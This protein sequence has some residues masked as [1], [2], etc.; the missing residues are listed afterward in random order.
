MADLA[1]YHR[2]KTGGAYRPYK[3]IEERRGVKTGA[4]EGPF[5]IRPT[6]SDGRQPWVKLDAATFEQAKAERNRKGSGEQI[7]AETP[8][9]RVA[10]GAAIGS[11]IDSKKRKSPATQQNYTAILNEFLDYL[12]VKFIDE[13][14][15]KVLDGYI[16]W[17][18]KERKAAP[19][20]IK[21]KTQV[22]IFM[23]KFAGVQKPTTLVKDLVP[24]VEEEPAE[25]YNQKDLETLFEYMEKSKDQE[26]YQRYMFFL[27]TACREKEVAH[28]QWKD[29]VV[30][31]SVP[32]FVVQAK[33][34]QK[35]NGERGAFSPKNHE[36]REVPLT[37]ELVDM[38]TA[39][40]KTSKS[41]WIFP[42]ENG[43]P[44]GH[45]LRKFKKI[46]FEAGLNCGKCRTTRRE[47]RY[48]KVV[49]EKRCDTFNEGCALHYLHRLRKT[50]ATFWH[51]HQV[52]LRT[53]QYYLGHKDLN[54]TQ[55]YLG[56]ENAEAVMDKINRPMF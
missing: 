15:S 19:K 44:E 29:I 53:I 10:V 45:F 4:F 1:I 46:A 36:R 34:Y 12:P 48:D 22:V 40:K 6:Y 55:K 32:H 54:T 50:R 30:K 49:V 26:A 25:P 8:G 21:N 7:A 17:L 27:V 23:L 16:T 9:N 47:G 20:T 52:P 43:D 39:R 18:E 3:R 35:A 42:N 2:P 28:A 38:L 24:V 56:I 33:S 51:T 31:G 13:I 41:D 37:R 11:F 14:T 5:Y